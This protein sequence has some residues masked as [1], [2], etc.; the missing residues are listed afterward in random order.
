MR[1][2][3]MIMSVVVAFY[4]GAC[5]ATPEK[6]DRR[7]VDQAFAQSQLAKELDANWYVASSKP[8]TFLP[9]GQAADAPTSPSDGQWVL[10]ETPAARWF[11]P[12]NGMKDVPRDKL[13][14]QATEG[15]IALQIGGAEWI[16]K[17]RIFSLGKETAVGIGWGIWGIVYVLVT[18]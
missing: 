9:K 5:A 10:V 14:E 2:L 1:K 3:R 15:S 17:G 18:P 7:L 12:K 16:T 13:H 8:L 11:V 4:L 6:V